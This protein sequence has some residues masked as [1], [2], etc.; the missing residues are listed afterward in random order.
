MEVNGRAGR[1]PYGVLK[2]GWADDVYF[3][4]EGV[5]GE[6]GVVLVFV[7]YDVVVGGGFWP[8]IIAKELEEGY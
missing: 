5:G 4:A 7:V 8:Y 6:R 3:H 2:G 1:T